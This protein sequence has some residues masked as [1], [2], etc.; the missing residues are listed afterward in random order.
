[1]INPKEKI[2]KPAAKSISTETK[3]T[4]SIPAKKPAIKMTKPNTIKP[5]MKPF[6]IGIG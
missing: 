4:A 2:I 5:L 6:S 1:M 3:A